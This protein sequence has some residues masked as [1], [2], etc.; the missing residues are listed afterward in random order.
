MVARMP[1]LLFLIS[2]SSSAPSIGA[3]P[4]VGAVQ[5]RWATWEPAALLQLGADPAAPVLTAAWTAQRV[6]GPLVPLPRRGHSATLVGKALYVY[7]GSEEPAHHCFRELLMLDLESMRWSRPRVGVRDNPPPLTGHTASLVYR[8][9]S[10]GAVDKTPTIF[11]IG[12]L[13]FYSASAES[14]AWHADVWILNTRTLTWKRA[15]G[16]GAVM[17]PRQG[18]SATVVGDR[19]LVFGGH[20]DAGL[21]PNA[22]LAMRVDPD[23]RSGKHAWAIVP[24]AGGAPGA[25][26]GHGAALLAGRYY[27]V[28]GGYVGVGGQSQNDVR[29]LDLLL[30][31]PPAAAAAKGKRGDAPP[32]PVRTWA[33]PHVGGGPPPSAR[34]D[35]T[36][37]VLQSAGRSS[38]LLAGGCSFPSKRCHNDLYLLSVEQ[39]GE[40]PRWSWSTPFDAAM[41]L[42]SGARGR[43]HAAPAAREQHTMTL[44]P[45]ARD[46]AKGSSTLLQWGGCLLDRKCYGEVS[47]LRLCADASECRVGEAKALPAPTAA[48]A[49][50]AKPHVDAPAC[51]SMCSGHGDC[52]ADGAGGHCSC[53]IVSKREAWYGADC[54]SR[55]PCTVVVRAPRTLT[56]PDGTL[57]VPEEDQGVVLVKAVT[58]ERTSRATHNESV[59]VVAVPL[60]PLARLSATAYDETTDGGRPFAVRVMVYHGRLLMVPPGERSV[61]NG[62]HAGVLVETAKAGA[63]TIVVNLRAGARPWLEGDVVIVGAGTEGAEGAEI[64][65]QADDDESSNHYRIAQVLRRSH[66]AGVEVVSAR[67]APAPLALP[68]VCEPQ[69]LHCACGR[70]G[71]C[72]KASDGEVECVCFPGWG[73]RRCNIEECPKN[74]TGPIFGE[75]ALAGPFGLERQCRCRYG[76]E[77]RACD[78]RVGC[79]DLGRECGANSKCVTRRAWI[80]PDDATKLIRIDA[81]YCRCAAGWG[82]PLC[83]VRQCPN[84]CTSSAAGACTRVLG[85]VGSV[86]KC[87]CAAGFSGSDCGSQPCPN[88]CSEHGECLPDG[89]GCKCDPGWEGK[90]C[91]RLRESPC[92]PHAR[93]HGHG[94]C[95]PAFGCQCD[96]G[97]AGHACSAAAA[98]PNDCSNAGECV[99]GVCHCRFGR[100]GRDCTQTDGTVC[101][102]GC[103]G[104][105]TCHLGQCFCHP[106]FDGRRCEDA[107]ACPAWVGHQH[108]TVGGDALAATATAALLVHRGG[109]S[110]TLLRPRRGSVNGA[111]VPLH[112]LAPLPP[113]CGGHGVCRWGKC[114]CAAG[115]QAPDCRPARP[116]VTDDSGVVCAGNG[117]CTNGT[118]FCKPGWH[119]VSCQRGATCPGNCSRNGFCFNGRCLCDLGFRGP[120]CDD[121]VPCPSHPLSNLSVALSGSDM[122]SGNGRCLRGR[123]YCNPGFS[124]ADCATARACPT[125]CSQHGRCDGSACVCDSGY[126]GDDCSIPVPCPFNCHGRGI[127]Y[128]GTC[129]CHP[130]FAGRSCELTVSC[131]SGCSGRG[132]C[133]EGKC[134]CDD[135]FYGRDC[136]QGGDLRRPCPANCS[137]HGI[138]ENGQC[139][140]DLGFRGVAC[141]R[142]QLCP[143][144]CSAHGLCRH[145][146]CFCDPGFSGR[147]CHV[148]Q[149]CAGTPACS[150]HGACAWGKC[151]CVDGYAEAD[152]SVYVAERVQLKLALTAP[153]A[154]RIPGLDCTGHGRCEWGQCG[155]VEGWHG[156]DCSQNTALG[157]VRV[158]Y[159]CVCVCAFPPI[160]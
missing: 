91:E 36:A 44:V 115:F 156:F 160:Q 52:V 23:V 8:A 57:V 151:F 69:R 131:P 133:I 96:A 82:G 103:S 13:S 126:T 145:G 114:F 45:S 142:A 5:P 40:G 73:G 24:T 139:V 64:T 60:S 77:G 51:P 41:S 47:L 134:I 1:V 159:V 101:P 18:H 20:S 150:G 90:G 38:L 137:S 135:D 65:G 92:G 116:C 98:C 22:L 121:P 99:A 118:C 130:G 107:V 39:G 141:S 129:G 61:A 11:V 123:C 21:A 127:C 32:R 143:A 93:C 136:A 72:V 155:C 111:L 71:K 81:G 80:V 50:T 138:C 16:A 58:R 117:I 105:G 7:G 79:G 97:W 4:R 149:T 56:S 12:G 122:C 157:E 2:S 67:L 34:E 25:R 31:P 152:C 124:G 29:V 125:S 53:W 48:P 85:S 144:N 100:Q 33:Q 26:H 83:N 19:I 68:R 95:F 28:F 112:S 37:T 110:R 59:A 128:L 88:Q 153:C 17:S 62:V 6:T 27:I 87:A 74:C 86:Y 42:A 78:Q 113:P 146:D 46:A 76:F 9:G 94:Q 63:T 43:Q 148:Q 55:A 14:S 15:P 89:R 66:P 3:G 54:A 132:D 106:G 75:C 109:R 108:L 154:T 35:M 30:K 119:G 120:A 70:G 158:A 84:N 147:S 49:P 104:R 140:C 10:V 102:F